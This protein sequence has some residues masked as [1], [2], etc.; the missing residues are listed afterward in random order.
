MITYGF[1]GFQKV[2]EWTDPTHSTPPGFLAVVFVISF[3]FL[4]NIWYVPIGSLDPI[5]IFANL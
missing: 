1:L 4:N 3:F 5:G 2:Q